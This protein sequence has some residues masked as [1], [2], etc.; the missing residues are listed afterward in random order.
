MQAQ[1]FRMELVI[2]MLAA[3]VVPAAVA[4]LIYFLVP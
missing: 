3:L 1:Q 4:A 2:Y